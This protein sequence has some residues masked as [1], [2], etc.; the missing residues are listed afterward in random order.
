MTQ[1]QF[2]EQEVKNYIK[3]LFPKTTEKQLDE[4]FKESDYR[5]NEEQNRIL[6]DINIGSGTK[7]KTIVMGWSDTNGIY[8]LVDEDRDFDEKFQEGDN[9]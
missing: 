3:F 7:Y 1:T 9:E 6:I 5:F 8:G 4:R 2:V